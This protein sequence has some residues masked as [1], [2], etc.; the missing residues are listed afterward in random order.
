MNIEDWMKDNCERVQELRDK[1]SANYRHMSNKRK[2][3][4]D[5][6]SHTREF[7]AGQRFWYRTPGLSEALQP[8]WQGP[9]EIREAL[10]WLAYKLDMDG[11]SKNVHVKFLTEDVSTIVKRVTTVLEDDGVGDDVTITNDKVLLRNRYS[12]RL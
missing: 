4:L 8:A 9:Y 11:K 10:N 1:A 12:T 7:K 3:L 2:E 6:T 5:K